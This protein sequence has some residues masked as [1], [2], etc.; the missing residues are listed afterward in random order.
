MIDPSS[1][2]TESDIQFIA[3]LAR[4]AGRMAA[5][6][7]A[8]I[9]VR[10]KTG[11]N[12]LVTCADIALS[13][14]ITRELAERFPEDQLI[15][16]EATPGPP[17]SNGRVW[18]IDPIDGTDNYVR[19]DSQYA[20]MIGLLVNGNAEFGCVY[21]PPDDYSYYGGMKFGVYKKYGQLPPDLVKRDYPV[22]LTKPVRLMM[23][24][25]DRKKNPWIKD[26]PDIDWLESGSVGIKVAK[27]IN[28]E[29]DV[30]VHLAGKL[31]L[32]DTAGPVAIAL[33]AG[34][35]VGTMKEDELSFPLPE[36]VHGT[37]VIIGRPGSL[38]WTRR[39]LVAPV[40]PK[41]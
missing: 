3:D 11:P 32:W 16:E 4:R 18:L 5:Q 40:E 17:T 33:G 36:I 20:V 23:G 41:R 1:I 13:E 6:M 19:N 38:E 21:N 12:D 15:S 10:H 37:V 34:L 14:L 39:T 35:E 8:S 2:L 31:K 24:W 30:F 29:A 26:L 27:V 9:D 28:D 25:R 7:R 22:D